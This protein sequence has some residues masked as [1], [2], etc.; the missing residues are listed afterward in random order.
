MSQYGASYM[1][2]HGY[3]FDEILMHYYDGITIG[4]T[5]VIINS[6]SKTSITQKFSSPNGKGSLILNNPDSADNLKITLNSNEINF[7]KSDLDN[8]KIKINLDK[9]ITKG[10]N[11]ITYHPLENEEG[12]S[13]KIWIEVFEQTKPE[14]FIRKILPGF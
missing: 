12:K 9:Y 14:S 7:S 4:T 3:T 1:G 6:D 2:K 5:P 11:E 8:K 10:L 13:I